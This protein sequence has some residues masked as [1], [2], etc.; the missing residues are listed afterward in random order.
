AVQLCKAIK[1]DRLLRRNL[2]MEQELID[3]MYK[4]T[5]STTSDLSVDQIINYINSPDKTLQLLAIQTYTKLKRETN[6]SINDMI[7]DGILSRCIELLD[8]DNVSLQFQIASLLTTITSDTSKQMKYITMDKII[9]KLVKLFKSAP[10]VVEQAVRALGNIIENK[11]YVRRLVL[12]YDA[13]LLLA[14]FIKSHISVT[15]MDDISWLLSNLCQ[16]NPPLTVELIK[17]VLSVF[18]CL[19]NNKNQYII[20]DVCRTLSYLTDGSKDNVQAI[21]ET[22]DIL[23]KLLECLTLRKETIVLPALRTLGNIVTI[24]NDAQ[25]NNVIFAGGLSRL[26]AVLRYYLCAKEDDIVKEAFWAIFKIIDNMNQIQNAQKIATWTIIALIT[27][28]TI[29]HLIQLVY[30]GVL[31]AFCNLLK[32]DDNQNIINALIGMAEILHATEKIGQTEKL[33][34]MIKKFG[35]LEKINDLQY[36]ENERIYRESLAIINAYFRQRVCISI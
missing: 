36:H 15:F 6:S 20:S 25:K 13:L 34:T 1:N 33:A 4:A 29:Q 23:P 9:P 12:Q 28:G 18:N 30:A 7:E 21:I 26:G 19:F 14:N 10:I 35:G 5:L 17:P 31:Q 2:D 22:A 8:C 16:K 11:S 3:L 24:G 27:Q 32:S